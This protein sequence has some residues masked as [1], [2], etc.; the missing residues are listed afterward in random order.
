MA[1]IVE[2]ARNN[3]HK[4]SSIVNELSYHYLKIK[5]LHKEQLEAIRSS[6]TGKHVMVNAPTGFGKSAK[7]QILPYVI[8]SLSELQL[9]TCTM[10]VVCPLVSLMIDQVNS[11][12][13]KGINACYLTA[14]T[15]LS[16]IITENGTVIPSLVFYSPEG[17]LN[18]ST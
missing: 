12:K 7:F 15:M 8:D 13:A 10:V 9:G 18:S 5:S 2:V 11:L 6:L 3:L 1:S 17:Y 16:D 4:F 14:Q